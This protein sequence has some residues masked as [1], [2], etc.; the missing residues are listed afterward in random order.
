MHTSQTPLLTASKRHLPVHAQKLVY[1]EWAAIIKHQDEMDAAYRAEDYL[2]QKDFQ[3]R[4]RDDLEKQ[5]LE[6]AQQLK[7]NQIR[8]AKLAE[9]ML[10]YQREKDDQKLKTEDAR[11]NALRNDMI[12]KQK[13][14]LAE[15]EN[16][17]K[18]AADQAQELQKQ[19]RE[20]ALKALEDQRR[21]DELRKLEKNSFARQ[22]KSDLG[23]QQVEKREKTK[24]ER[25]MDRLYAQMGLVK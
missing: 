4:Y 2:R 22:Y 19:Y 18:L 9:E 6:A 8:D 1:N 13:E 15:A 24:A 12:Q 16:K 23:M 25:E 14:S 11:V 7:A 3:K 17:R 5:R 20:S 10:H 21:E